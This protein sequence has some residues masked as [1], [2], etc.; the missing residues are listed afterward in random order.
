M[1]IEPT[2]TQITGKWLSRD[3]RTIADE[4]CERIDEL[5]RSHLRQL[6][7]DASGWDVLYRDPGDGRLWE[8][9]YPQSEM[10]GGGPPQLRCLALDEARG[11]YGDIVH[12]V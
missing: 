10:H 8:L 1:K 3:A 2:E 11:K 7:G 12:A 5:V 4:A 9:T 6:G